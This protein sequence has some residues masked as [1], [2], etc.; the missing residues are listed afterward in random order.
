MQFFD[1]PVGTEAQSRLQGLFA[2]QKCGPAKSRRRC[3]PSALCT[4]KGVYWWHASRMLVGLSRTDRW[5]FLSPGKKSSHFFAHL[6]PQ[7]L[8]YPHPPHITNRRMTAQPCHAVVYT[9]GAQLEKQDVSPPIP[10]STLICLGQYSLAGVLPGTN[11]YHVR[12]SYRMP[13]SPRLQARQSTI[14]S[15][16]ISRTLEAK[17]SISA[18]VP[19]PNMASR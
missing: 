9:R 4:G 3:P 12:P 6:S 10:R 13:S 1:I 16:S 2:C 5:N 11:F 15:P 18:S 8:L 17:N 19:H 14:R 7:V